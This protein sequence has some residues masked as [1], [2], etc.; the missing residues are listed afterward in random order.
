M[1][2]RC[3]RPTRRPRD[4]R[5]TDARQR[6]QL[7]VNSAIGARMNQQIQR[8]LQARVESFASDVT[9]ILTRA[10]ADAVAQALGSAAPRKL[11][12]R[13]ATRRRPQ[14]GRGSSFEVDAVFAEVKRKGGRRMEELAKALKTTTK[15]LSLPMKKLIVAKKVKAR[16]V[17]RG[18]RYTVA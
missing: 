7:P 1:I 10:V 14:S 12:T 5:R 18:T 2:A 16:G 15:S 11:N 9:A 17:A 13:V 3:A 8:E 4:V 6:S